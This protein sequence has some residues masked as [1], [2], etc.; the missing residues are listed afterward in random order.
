MYLRSDSVEPRFHTPDR[1]SR[2][3]RFA[4][5]LAQMLRKEAATSRKQ[6]RTIEQ[7][8]G[9]LTDRGYDGGPLGG[10]PYWFTLVSNR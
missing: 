10:A 1:P 6:K 2:L 3:D 9:D 8:H 7:L 4:D 5:K